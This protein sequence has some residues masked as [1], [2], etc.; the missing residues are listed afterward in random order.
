MPATSEPAPGS[1]IPSAPIRSPRMAGVR[2]RCFWSSVPNFHTGGVAMLTCA[3]MP[4]ASPP[5]PQRESSCA[6]IASST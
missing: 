6:R 2:K 3:P 4:A 1:V 5:D